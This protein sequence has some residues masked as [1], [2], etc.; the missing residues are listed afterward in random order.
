LANVGKDL[1]PKIA[2]SADSVVVIEQLLLLAGEGWH[3]AAVSEAEH[4]CGLLG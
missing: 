4:S 2:L 3:G 1:R